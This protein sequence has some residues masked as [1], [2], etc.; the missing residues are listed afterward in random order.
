MRVE[1]VAPIDRFFRRLV[2]YGPPDAEERAA[3]QAILTPPR[4]VAAGETMIRQF[5]KPQ[6]STLLLDGLVGRVVTLSG[7]S[8]QITALQ[9]PGDFVDLHAFLLARMDHS[10]V[11]LTDTLV[12]TAPHRALR[13]LMD[14]Y[15]RLGRALWYLTLVDA[16]IHRHWLTVVGRRQATGRAAH[17]LCE[18][19][20]RL[21][22]VGLARDGAFTLGLTQA[23]VGD[24]LSLSAVH[25]NR[26]V[27]ELRARG[28]VAWDRRQV[29]IRDWDGLCALAEFEP[30]YL[31]LE[32][33][34]ET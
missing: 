3:L 23:E 30:T 32:D 16:S 25:V 9:V 7:G 12:T 19:Y 10:V 20:V 17:L 22:D 1:T 2:R 27:Q 26:V 11:A 29:V 5:D 8:Q 13:S 33:Q 6:A 21:Q 31:Q 28:L 18:L 14:R 24:V 4:T 15:P 34:T